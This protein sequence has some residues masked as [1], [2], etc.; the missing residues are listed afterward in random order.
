MPGQLRLK[1]RV[2]RGCLGQLLE[3]C[4]QRRG[5]RD[6]LGLGGAVRGKTDASLNDRVA[7]LA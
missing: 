6:E 7:S 3:H 4:S 2:A 5:R 1:L